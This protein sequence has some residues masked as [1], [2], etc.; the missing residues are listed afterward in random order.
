LS[1]NALCGYRDFNCEASKGQMIR[2]W[3]E[4]E[5]INEFGAVSPGLWETTVGAALRGRPSARHLN[6]FADCN[7][8]EGRPTE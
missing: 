8:N 1:V 7:R 5:L 3:L 2:G 4:R 6:L